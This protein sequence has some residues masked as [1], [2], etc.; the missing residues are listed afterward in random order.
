MKKPYLIAFPK[1]G[2]TLLGYISVAEK[3]N[4][5]FEVKR[6]YWTYFTP[7]NIIRGGHAHYQLEQI[8]VAVAGKIDVDIETLDGVHTQFILDSADKGLFIPKL[9]WRTMKYTHNAVQ[10]CI[11]SMAYQE[12]DYIRDYQEFAK[13]VTAEMS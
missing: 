12:S 10:M 1:I 11:A 3:E 4:L 8:L 13:L 9:C 7:E 2:E 5:P 6:I